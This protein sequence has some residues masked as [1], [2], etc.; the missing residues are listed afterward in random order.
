MARSNT[1]QPLFDTFQHSKYTA[2]EKNPVA[3]PAL[4]HQPDVNYYLIPPSKLRYAT[5]V[6]LS[7]NSYHG[8]KGLNTLGSAGSGEI[9][10][11]MHF[12]TRTGVTYFFRFF[13]NHVE[14]FDGSVWATTTGLPTLTGTTED[15][16]TF[17]FWGD[18][19]IFSNGVDGTYVVDPTTNVGATISAAPPALWLTVAA[20]RLIIAGS[21]TDPNTIFWSIRG[22]FT[23]FSGLGSG[24][25]DM[26]ST[27]G[28]YVDSLTG[29]YPVADQISFVVRSRSIWSM[30]ETGS[31]DAPFQFSKSYPEIGG[32]FPFG[33]AIVPG[34]VIVPTKGDIHRVTMQ[35]GVEHIAT[36]VTD[37]IFSGLAVGARR[38]VCGAANQQGN[39]Y[40]LFV[41]TSTNNHRVHTCTLGTERDEPYQWTTFEYPFD[42]RAMSVGVPDFALQ[43][44]ELPG[45]SDS[46]SGQTDDL[47][48]TEGDTGLILIPDATNAYIVIEDAT[49]TDNPSGRD[50]TVNGQ[51]YKSGFDI[52]TGILVSTSPLDK[53][54]TNDMQVVIISN[55]DCIVKVAFSGDGGDTWE[56]EQNIRVEASDKP[57]VYRA[58]CNLERDSLLMRVR[59][60]DSGSIQMTLMSP[61]V[62]GGAMVNA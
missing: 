27:P 26:L 51:R 40:R 11:A 16:F 48:V 47:G 58:T 43:T 12:T 17:T 2:G 24:S 19:L 62:V 9:V 61:S 52:Q 55:R 46:L 15:I 18:L 38:R 35:N 14:R 45:D 10:Y 32:E 7:N 42:I 44:D 59:S 30:V 20:K 50:V 39:F 54:L 4:G 37:H 49:Q 1:K 29:V 33:V 36:G 60:L 13:T 34:G 25:E 23:D 3:V 31:F 28:G 8:R 5:N 41:P 53:S 57:K 21:D 22:D 56:Q 6:V